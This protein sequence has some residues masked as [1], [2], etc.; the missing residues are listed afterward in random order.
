MLV[1]GDVI[2]DRYWWGEASRLSPEA[3]VPIVRLERSSLRP[4]G[5]GNTAANLAAMGATATLF[6]VTGED[7][8]AA[9]LRAV[10]EESHVNATALF[11]QAG[12]RTTT[13]TRI[14]A[15][16][17]Q[18]VRVDAEHTMPI[19]GEL[20]LGTAALVAREMQSAGAIV[21]SD[22]AKGFLSHALLESVIGSAAEAKKPVFIDPK[23]AD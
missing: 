12:R 2:L 13:K 8:E 14:I 5:A 4:G 23:G 16:H 18:V 3:P 19:P 6:G 11:A 22:Y 7:P 20:S 10:L 9:E 21:I 17:Q 1:L 15:G